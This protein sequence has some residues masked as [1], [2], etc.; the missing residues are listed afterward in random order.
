MHLASLSRSKQL[1]LIM[2]SFGALI[3]TSGFVRTSSVNFLESKVVQIGDIDR[4]EVRI[5]YRKSQIVKTSVPVYIAYSSELYE[6]MMIW[7]T[8]RDILS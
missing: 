8:D 4:G 5:Q 1:A 2:L 6:G 3:T 7:C